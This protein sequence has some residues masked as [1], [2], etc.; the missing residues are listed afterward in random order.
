MEHLCPQCGGETASIPVCVTWMGSEGRWVGCFGCGSALE[1]Y[2]ADLDICDWS[3]TCGLNPENP[4][5]VEN[6]LRSPPWA[7]TVVY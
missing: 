5:S 4:R 2:C 3:W 6:D 7:D 1:F